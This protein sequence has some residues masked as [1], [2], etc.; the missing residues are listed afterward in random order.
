MQFESTLDGLIECLQALRQHASGD[1]PVNINLWGD[2]NIA[3][4]SVFYDHNVGGEE[5]IYL[6]GNLED[7]RESLANFSLVDTDDSI[8]E[9]IEKDYV[10]EKS[11]LKAEEITEPFTNDL[12]KVYDLLT[13]HNKQEFLKSYSY[14]NGIAYDNTCFELFP[15]KVLDDMDEQ[16]QQVVENVAYLMRYAEN[17]LIEENN[18]RPTRWNV[19]AEDLKWAIIDHVSENFTDEQAELF[20]EVC[21]GMGC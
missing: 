4:Q 14:I 1:T 20:R 11:R 12:D 6:E 19:Q 9:R 5:S 16:N 18:G 3:L 10:R 13:I 15:S 8:T 21:D 2:R 17:L 7:R